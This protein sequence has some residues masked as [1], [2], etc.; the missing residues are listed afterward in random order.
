VVGE[1]EDIL[2]HL[3]TRGFKMPFT[4]K[5]LADGTLP[6]SEGSLYTAPA[7]TVAYVKRVSIFNS[8]SVEQTVMIY[9]QA[10]GGSSRR[11]RRYVL[12]Q[13]ESAEVLEAGDSVHLGE[14]DS[15][16]AATTTSGAVDYYITGVEE[17]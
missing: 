16:R 8:N 7:D 2:L 15:I 17:S 4:A 14:G 9:L 12:A 5:R 13:N 10:S 1:K 3:V 6:T 11:W